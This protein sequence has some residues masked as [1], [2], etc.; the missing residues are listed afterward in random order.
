[1]ESMSGDNNSRVPAVPKGSTI[2]RME[3]KGNPWIEF[4][5]DTM[6][7]SIARGCTCMTTTM[8]TMVEWC[9]MVAILQLI[10]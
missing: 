3:S 6:A 7:S 1:M 8:T 10:S 9:M 4:L 2:P 5:T